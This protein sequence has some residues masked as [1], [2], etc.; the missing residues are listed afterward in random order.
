M[1]NPSYDVIQHIA[2]PIY[3]FNLDHDVDPDVIANY[4]RKYRSENPDSN[5]S[6]V[7]AWHSVYHTHKNTGIFDHLLKAIET[8]VFELCLSLDP[9]FDQ[10]KIK[11]VVD[12]CWAIMY[13]KGDHAEWHN[14]G[15]RNCYSTVYYA[16]VGDDTPIVF[17]DTWGDNLEIKPTKGMLLVFPS[18]AS[19]M[20][21]QLSSDRERLAF[22][23]NLVYT[24]TV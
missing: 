9:A 7:L 1:L 19:H 21:P 6:N 23:A 5:S 12:N 13:K 18:M 24:G 15:T 16:D 11:P 14:H 3:Q 4:I 20:V 22:A 17:E 2:Y 8:Q 10:L